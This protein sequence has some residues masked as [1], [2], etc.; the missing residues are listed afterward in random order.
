MKIAIVAAMEREVRPLIRGWKVRT[1]EHGGRRYRLFEDGK[2]ENGPA[3]NREAALVC[4]GI[5]AEAARRATEAI[6]REVNPERVISVGFAGA[7]DGSLHVGDVLQPRTVINAAD[8]ARTD[9][10]SGEGI[11][12]SSST[13]A[14]REQKTRF[15][16]A[17]GAV[18][19]DMEAAAVANGAEARGVEF[20]ALKAISDASDFAMPEIDGFVADDG[21]FRSAK[22]AC[23]V[24]LRPWLWRATVALARNSSEASRAL[25]NAIAGYLG[26]KKLGGATGVS[27]LKQ[28]GG[29]AG[30]PGSPPARLER[31]L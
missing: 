13:V 12:L 1:I 30:T 3:E 7:L 11:L 29:R 9:A 14:S 27:P 20:A 2:A 6:I 23:H 21:T 24:A 26:R 4:G 19:V 18:A 8:G 25:C 31:R 22:F 28:F 15:A 10:G 17:Y 5:G 16:Q